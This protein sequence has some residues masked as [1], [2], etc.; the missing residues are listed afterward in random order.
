MTFGLGSVDALV[1]L[2]NCCSFLSQTFKLVQGEGTRATTK[3]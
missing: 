2:L 1:L 3:S